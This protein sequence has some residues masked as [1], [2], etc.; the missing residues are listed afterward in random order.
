[1]VGYF[2][3]RETERGAK[4]I[5]KMDGEMTSITNPENGTLQLLVGYFPR[6]LYQFAGINSRPV[7][8]LSGVNQGKRRSFLLITHI[9]VT[10]SHS[11]LLIR[12]RSF[13]IWA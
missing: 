10:I 8:F 2:I 6:S 13:R 1:M 9:G 5:I 4:I 3:C 11:P 12:N 7:L